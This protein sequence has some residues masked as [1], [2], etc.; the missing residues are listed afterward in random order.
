MSAPTGWPLVLGHPAPREPVEQLAE[1]HIRLRYG[2]L[3][4]ANTLEARVISSGHITGK[5]AGFGAVR[6][7]VLAQL[8]LAQLVD[9][10]RAGRLVLTSATGQLPRSR[11]SCLFCLMLV[12]GP[13]DDSTELVAL[14]LVGGLLAAAGGADVVTE[15]R[16]QRD[17]LAEQHGSPTPTHQHWDS[18]VD[19]DR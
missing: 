10:A 6:A 11:G 19:T 5:P 9:E 7:K 15:N 14:Q 18:K 4:D 13:C 17:L 3:P 2:T 8:L 12:I 16:A 1:R